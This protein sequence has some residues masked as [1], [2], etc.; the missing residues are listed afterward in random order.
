MEG[1]EH[2][3]QRDI[4]DEQGEVWGGTR[5]RQ[6]ERHTHRIFLGVSQLI[7]SLGFERKMWGERDSEV[8][9]SSTPVTEPRWWGIE[10]GRRLE[11]HGRKQ[12]L[13]A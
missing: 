11:T 7:S 4:E 8:E 5:R 10:A 3:P 13:R 12:G 9:M 1:G 2:L 6:E